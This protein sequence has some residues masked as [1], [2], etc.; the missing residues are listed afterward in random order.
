MRHV[1]F[2]SLVLVLLGC[3]STA[4]IERVDLSAPGWEIRQGQAL[5]KADEEKPEIAGDIVLSTHPSGADYLQFSKTLPLLS[6]HLDVSGWA[7][8]FTP[9]NKRYSGKGLPPKR[10]GW[11]QVMRALRG[12][13]LHKPW[14]LIY[15]SPDFIAVENDASGER[16]EI[17][18]QK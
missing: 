2:V 10:V 13:T 12:E 17:H 6:A 5:W 4:P 9:E 15:P 1:V 3:A 7:I 8:E 16:L 14:R 18:F 11:L